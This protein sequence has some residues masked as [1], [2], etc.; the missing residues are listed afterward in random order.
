MEQEAVSENQNRVS[1]HWLFLRDQIM[2][3]GSLYPEQ[4]GVRLLYD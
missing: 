1:R 4:Q 2:E 3:A